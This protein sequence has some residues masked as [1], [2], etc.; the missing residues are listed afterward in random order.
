[1]NLLALGLATWRVSFFLVKEDGPGLIARRIREWTGIEHDTDGNVVSYNDYTPLSCV[2]CTSIW[3]AA[4]MMLLPKS[5]HTWLAA[6]ALAVI[7]EQD[8]LRGSR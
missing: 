6:S 4:A 7:L 8:R 3:V 1:V 5:A 2:F